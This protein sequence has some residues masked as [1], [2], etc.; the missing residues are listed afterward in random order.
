MRRANRKPMISSGPRGSG[1]AR[2]A[3]YKGLLRQAMSAHQADDLD[4]AERLYENVLEL[5]V[6]QPDALHYLGVLYHQR[7]RSDEGAELIRTA[8]KI[9][10][11]H[12]DAHNNL[13]NVHKECGEL[14]Q[15]EA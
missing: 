13:G 12:P 14:A 2:S 1:V 4:T 3:D 11:K 15:A 8:L 5:R 6:A 10:P 9:T 7:G